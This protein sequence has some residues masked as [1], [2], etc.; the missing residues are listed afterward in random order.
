MMEF[1]F[2]QQNSPLNMY[3]WMTFSWS[4]ICFICMCVCVIYIYI[5]K[6]TSSVFIWW[7]A[8]LIVSYFG[9]CEQFCY[10]RD[11]ADIF[12]MQFVSLGYIITSVIAGLFG[13]P[14]SCSIINPHTVYDTDST[15][16]KSQQLYMRVSF[17]P[18]PC[19]QCL[20]SMDWII[21]L[22]LGKRWYLLVGL[23]SIHLL[24]SDVEH[25]SCIYCWLFVLLLRASPV[26]CPFF[27][28]FVFLNFY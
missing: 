3:I 25:F 28:F 13:K 27:S 17:I 1:H 15:N 9:Y 12:L 22:L 20:F 6:I 14:I 8:G 23:V 5:Y 16:L 4:I 11:G 2:L 21:F 19:Q 18:H 24:T 10:E 7:G 26:L